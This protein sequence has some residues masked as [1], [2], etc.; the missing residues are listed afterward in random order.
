MKPSDES[1]ISR[2]EW[3]NN[4]ASESVGSSY[5]I[6]G[7]SR[8][9]FSSDSSTATVAKNRR[10]QLRQT[11]VYW[12]PLSTLGQCEQGSAIGCQRPAPMFCDARPELRR[13]RPASGDRAARQLV[14][15]VSWTT[16]PT[17]QFTVC[18]SWT[19]F[20]IGA[21]ELDS[22]PVPRPVA[23]D[24]RRGGPDSNCHLRQNPRIFANACRLRPEGAAQSSIPT[25][26]L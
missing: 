15:S 12:C 5:P 4:A 6:G 10:R 20:N 1:P 9:F 13:S 25:P 21:S 17:V 2:D 24:L 19:V 16:V 7:V 11:T 14:L 26:V 23:G 18:L 8:N 22:T 3:W